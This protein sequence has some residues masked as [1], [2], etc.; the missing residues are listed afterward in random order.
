[1]SS[2]SFSTPDGRTARLL[3]GR[4]LD[5]LER[6]DGRWRIALRRATVEVGLTADAA[7]M[8]SEY[9][10]GMGFLKGLRD[11]RD[12]AYRRPLTLEETPPDHRWEGPEKSA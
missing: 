11:R 1:M 10:R 2:V 3:A 6:R 9:F 4:Y 5:R 7:F 8:N 12:L